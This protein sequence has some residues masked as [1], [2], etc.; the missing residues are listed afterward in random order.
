[1][2]F[3]V[4]CVYSIVSRTPKPKESPRHVHRTSSG[5][6][7]FSRSKSNTDAPLLSRVS[8]AAPARRSILAPSAFPAIAGCAAVHRAS[9]QRSRGSHDARFS[10]RGSRAFGSNEQQ[11][12]QRVVVVV[13]RGEVRAGP[14]PLVHGVDVRA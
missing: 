6:I 8:N 1:M 7:P 5:S 3:Y 2:S 14:V 9:R 11:N 12:R 10:Q 4:L 13:A